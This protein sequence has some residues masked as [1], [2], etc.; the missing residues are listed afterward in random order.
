MEINKD[1]EGNVFY[2]QDLYR[3]LINI[4]FGNFD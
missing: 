2:K 1:L 4:P 3:E